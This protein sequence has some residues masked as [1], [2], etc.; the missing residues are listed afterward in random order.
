[1]TAVLPIPGGGY[2]YY[3]SYQ[4]KQFSYAAFGGRHDP[5]NQFL[6]L[7]PKYLPVYDSLNYIMIYKLCESRCSKKSEDDPRIRCTRRNSVGFLLNRC[8]YFVLEL[9][10]FVFCFFLILSVIIDIS[11]ATNRTNVSSLY[12]SAT[13]F[14]HSA[15]EFGELPRVAR[16]ESKHVQAQTP[17]R[18]LT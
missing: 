15:S 6:H 5:V 10:T 13:Y 17:H 12:S 9:T 7:I 16:F 2:N 11:T 4:R 3:R 8:L 14:N 1:M 18:A